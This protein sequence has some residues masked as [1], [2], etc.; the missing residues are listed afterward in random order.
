MTFEPH[1]LKTKYSKTWNTFAGFNLEG[2]PVTKVTDAQTIELSN[3]DE[4]FIHRLSDHLPTLDMEPEGDGIARMNQFKEL[5]IQT[6]LEAR[7]E[8]IK[9][10]YSPP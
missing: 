9:D 1:E 6:L 4:Y 5:Y 8:Y 10:C 7:H 2:W 3:F